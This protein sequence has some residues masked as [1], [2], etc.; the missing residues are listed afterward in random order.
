MELLDNS[1]SKQHIIDLVEG[2]QH[3]YR[4]I[5]SLS[6][7]EMKTLKTFNNI[8]PKPRIVQLLKLLIKAPILFQ[9]SLMVT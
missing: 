9:K 5:Y 1:G 6:Q 8:H 3:L 2:N 7:V 4:P